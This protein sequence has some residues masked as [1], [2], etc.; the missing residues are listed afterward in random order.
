[1]TQ[2]NE[3]G[4][5]IRIHTERKIYEPSSVR[6]EQT[7]NGGQKMVPKE[8]KKIC[9]WKRMSMNLPKQEQEGLF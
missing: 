4:R 9:I 1:M 3:K 6:A 8:M 7:S 5:D 2:F